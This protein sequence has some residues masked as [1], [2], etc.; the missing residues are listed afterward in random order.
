MNTRIQVEHPVT[1]SIT[2]IDIVEEQIHIAT[3]NHLPDKLFSVKSSGH[4]IEARIYAENPHKDFISSMGEIS[5]LSLPGKSR[6]DTF[7]EEKTIITPHFDSMLGKLIVTG[8]DRS[9][10]IKKLKSSLKQTHIHGVHT[11]LFYLNQIAG[12]KYFKENNVS[13]EYLESNIAEYIYG[14]HRIVHHEM[15]QRAI[16]GAF[17]WNNFRLQPL[18]PKNIWEKSGPDIHLNKFKIYLEGEEFLIGLLDN[19]NFTLNGSR[20]TLRVINHRNNKLTFTLNDKIYD[21]VYSENKNKPYDN[22]ELEGI[23]YKVASPVVLGMSEYFLKQKKNKHNDVFNQIVSPLFGKVIDINV[24]EH[25]IVR[26]GDVLLTTESMKTENH[27]VSPGEGTIKKILVHK[28][29]QVKENG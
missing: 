10:A 21:I 15:N 3:G 2:G 7:I 14:Y 25:D 20:L 23:I 26:K 22:Y 17:I 18:K 9:D 11:N 12:N 27:I 5:Y 8:I 28:G 4:A 24:Q 13:T 29:L 6:F 16:I 19:Q 1:E